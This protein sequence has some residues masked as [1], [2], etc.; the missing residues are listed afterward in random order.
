MATTAVIRVRLPPSC[1]SCRVEFVEMSNQGVGGSA[2]VGNQFDMCRLT[3]SDLSV[4]LKPVR[5]GD[6]T[7]QIAASVDPGALA[8]DRGGRDAE[9]SVASVP[10]YRTKKQH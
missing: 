9:E 7:N 3:D 10:A 8:A 5:A 4:M 2:V 1:E 6:D